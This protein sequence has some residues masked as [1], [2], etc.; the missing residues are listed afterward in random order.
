MSLPKVVGSEVKLGGKTEHP[1][2]GGAEPDMHASLM[3]QIR[4]F[5]KGSGKRR[6]ASKSRGQEK[7][8]EKQQLAEKHSKPKTVDTNPTL[9]QV[10]Q[11]ESAHSTVSSQPQRDPGMQKEIKQGSE[12]QQT[13]KTN[14]T[15]IKV[16][17]DRVMREK[18]ATKDIPVSKELASHLINLSSANISQ[19]LRKSCSNIMAMSVNKG[20]TSEKDYLLK[21]LE[22][23]MNQEKKQ[24]NADLNARRV[25]LRETK[26]SQQN[27]IT[28]LENKQKQEIAEMKKRHDQ[29]CNYIEDEFID[30]SE[31]L[32]KEIELL[33]NELES[34]SAP[35][36]ILSAIVNSE[37]PPRTPTPLRSELTELEAEL[38][39]CN[40]SFIC[41]PPTK[42]YQC[43]EGDLFCQKC[44]DLSGLE[45]CPDCGVGLAGQMSRNKVLENIAIK[46]FQN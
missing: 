25:Q 17:M 5:A 10:K 34:M 22:E 7:V 20:S 23:L 33:E 8:A 12:T 39:C 36:Q 16:A 4:D 41:E 6:P 11:Q 40:C 44:K 13:S 21:R 37:V 43:P 9:I 42:I 46:Y 27:D 31:H 26:D 45:I 38:Q 32:I 35:S 29:E 2:A 18:S 28:F 30:K 15:G 1:L 24:V 3:D 14:S 19:E